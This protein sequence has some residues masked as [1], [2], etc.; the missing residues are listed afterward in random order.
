M[1]R[2]LFTFLTLRLYQNYHMR[3]TPKVKAHRIKK[4]VVAYST[5]TSF[6]SYIPNFS[7]AAIS[8]ISASLCGYFVSSII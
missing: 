8:A 4:E 7:F 5:T 2:S 3:K 6:E 1:I